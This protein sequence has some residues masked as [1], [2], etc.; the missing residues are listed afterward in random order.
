MS[1]M[2]QQFY[3]VAL[4]GFKK[5]FMIWGK[6]SYREERRLKTLTLGS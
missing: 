2:G 4:D 6:T 1:P 5:A 3:D